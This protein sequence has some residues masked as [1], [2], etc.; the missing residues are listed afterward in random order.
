MGERDPDRNRS[1]RTER[2]RVSLKPGRQTDRR[3]GGAVT[4]GHRKR[5][6]EKQ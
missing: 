6:R 1:E 2:E 4:E 3:G 5:K